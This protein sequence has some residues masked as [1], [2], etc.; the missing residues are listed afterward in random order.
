MFMAGWSIL[1]NGSVMDCGKTIDSFQRNGCGP[2]IDRDVIDSVDDSGGNNDELKC[3]FDQ[4]LSTVLK[5]VVSRGCIRPIPA[6]LGDGRSLDLFR[7][8]CVVREGGGFHLV[9][10]NGLW[11]FVLHDLGLD[12]GVSASV[13]LIYSKYLGELE[14]WLTGNCSS[15]GNGGRDCSETTGLMPLDLETEFRGLLTNW[16]NKKIKDNRRALSEFEKNDKRVEL[17]IKK[18]ET[19]LCNTK[20]RHERCNGFGKRCSNNDSIIL[21]NDEKLCNNDSSNTQ[22]E[23]FY[24]KRK[25][26]SLS[27]MLNWVIQIAKYPDNPLIGSIPEPSKWKEHGD[28]ELWVQAIRARDALLRRRHVENIQQSLLPVQLI[29]FG[30]CYKWFC[31]T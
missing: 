8:F 19:D 3:L 5:E 31:H 21:D 20:R 1:A 14:K 27:G 13:K 23:S 22:K 28:K 17:D 18:S 25:R 16:P 15:L 11:D 29:T 12:L 6:M 7:L 30:P 4:V 10:K 9:S 26:E 24:R 2:E